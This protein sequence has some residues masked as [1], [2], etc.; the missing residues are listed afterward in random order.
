MVEVLEFTKKDTP[1]GFL[2]TRILP[3]STGTIEIRVTKSSEK[4]GHTTRI[5][6]EIP[7]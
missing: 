4:S 3:L 1:N 5:T 6:G 7:T 2:S